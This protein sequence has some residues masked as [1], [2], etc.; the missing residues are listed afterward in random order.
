MKAVTWQGKRDVRV[1]DVP[2]PKIEEPT[3]AI[4]RV[5]ST[6]ICGSDLHLYEVLAP[7]LHAGDILGH[8]PMG[9]VEEVGDAVTHA[10]AGRPRGGA[11]QHLLRVVL[12][13]RPRAA[14]PSARRRRY[15]ARARARRCSATPRCT[16]ACPA[17]R[18]STCACRR[19]TSGRSRSRTSG[20]DERYLFLSDMLPDRVAGRAVRG[21]AE[22]GGTLAVFGL[23]PVGQMAA[24]IALHQR[25]R[26]RDR[27][28][29][30]AGAAGRWHRGTGI[31]VLDLDRAGRRRR[32]SLIDMV[33][34]RG[35]DAVIDAVG[36]EAHGSPRG[37]LA[38]A[39]AGLLPDARRPAAHRQGCA[40]TGWRRCTRRSRRSAAAARSRSAACTAARWTRFR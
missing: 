19:P 1:E 17:A 28:R 11:L 16:A 40:S 27:A 32:G 8:E 7:Y 4:I 30:G 5:T 10:A 2:D 21:R 33:D 23:G 25:R 35:P 18:P 34:G 31:E 15:A 14:T 37:K 12:D 9:I 38:Q 3:D 13:V 36:M 29:P 6:A 24:R 20:P 26:A 39:A 22:P